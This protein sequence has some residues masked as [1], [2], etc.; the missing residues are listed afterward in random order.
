[1][2]SLW[3]KS[4]N[5]V[6][7]FPRLSQDICCD[8]CIV[9]AGIFG[10]TCA[11]YLNLL[12]FDVVVIDKDDIAGKTTGNTT[13]KITSQH[14]LFYSYLINNF[15]HHFARLYLEANESAITN[16]KSIIDKENISCDF[17]FENNFVYTTDFDRLKS[18]RDEVEAV[19]SLN[20]PCEFA[21][22][23]GLPFNIA[24]S[25]CFKNQAQFHPLKYVW[26]LCNSICDSTRFF[27]HTTV[28]DIRQDNGS[29]VVC[30]DDVGYK[31]RSKF[32]IL[33]CHY[34]FINVPGFY[35]T[36]MYQSSSYLIAV[37]TKKSLFDGMFISADS[38]SFSFRTAK[39]GKKNLLLIGGAEHKT[40]SYCNYDSTYGVLENLAKKY[41]PDC[42]VLFRWN[43]RD[44]VSLDKIP[45]IGLFANNLPNFY[46]G[47]GFKK[48]G[49]S[50]SNV[51]AN[52]VVDMITGKDNVYSSIFNSSRL[53]PIKN[54]DEFKNMVVQSSRSLLIDKIKRSYLHFEDIPLNSGGIVEVNGDKVGFFR[55]VDDNIFAV[56]PFCTHLGCLLSWND[57]DK[58]WDCPCHGSRFD[59]TGKNLYDPAFKDLG[60]FDV[61]D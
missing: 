5:D 58:T 43:T 50:L 23:V 31:V 21:S 56:S 38:P 30:C 8:V 48:W 61:I 17:S 14:G 24:G 20:F 4:F 39:F 57:V 7:N 55:D 29:Y 49:M 16:I 1:M 3:S 44:C 47:T 40:G 25:V 10:V 28:S 54:R 2:D 53:N 12:G 32:V 6:R 51:A 11:Y 52:I 42:D 26:G 19:R 18:I 46:V 35:F 13:G 37:D 33:A 41:Y 45:Y 60:V 9:G 36:K 22:S 27:T 34:P 59:Y 15:G